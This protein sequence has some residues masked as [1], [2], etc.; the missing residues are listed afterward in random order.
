MDARDAL[1]DEAA[2][3]AVALLDEAAVLDAP[4]AAAA[5]V[6][7]ETE[8]FDGGLVFGTALDGGLVFGGGWESVKTAELSS[9]AKIKESTEGLDVESSFVRLEGLNLGLD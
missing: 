2:A 7:R 3:E 1:L 8:T 6:V 4:A 5:V 9:D